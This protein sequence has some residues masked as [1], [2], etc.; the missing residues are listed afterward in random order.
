MVRLCAVK[1]VCHVGFKCTKQLPGWQEANMG[2]RQ[3]R[4]DAHDL[5]AWFAM[6]V[7][8]VMLIDGVCSAA[9]ECT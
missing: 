3:A 9:P 5:Q 1:Q 7:E 2:V 4:D 8:E 6:N